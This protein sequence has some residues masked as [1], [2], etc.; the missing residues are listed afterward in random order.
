MSAITWASSG[1]SSNPPQTSSDVIS[2]AGQGTVGAS[3]TAHGTAGGAGNGISGTMHLEAS[4]G[5]GY[6]VLA[7]VSVLALPTGSQARTIA[8][9]AVGS[10]TLAKLVWAPS[11]YDNGYF[12]TGLWAFTQVILP[13]SAPVLPL[14]VTLNQQVPVGSTSGPNPYGI[15]INCFSDLDPYFSLVGGIQCLAQDLVHLI[16][17][18]ALPALSQGVTDSELGIIQGN[19][20]SELQSDERVQAANVILQLVDGSLT[21]TVAVQPLNPQGTAQPFQFIASISQAGSSLLSL[22]SL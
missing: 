20:V 8:A 15:D 6:T 9:Q 1:T 19:M 13:V 17:P 4:S 10:Y 3:F 2:L 12:D 7:S 5:S 22:T 14:P 18:L 16:Q 11:A 21:T